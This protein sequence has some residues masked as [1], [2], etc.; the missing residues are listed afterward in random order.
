MLIKGLFYF[1]WNSLGTTTNH[2]IVCCG[3][4]VCVPANVCFAG[5]CCTSKEQDLSNR[6]ESNHRAKPGTDETRFRHIVQT[7]HAQAEHILQLWR[8]ST[9]KCDAHWL[10]W[11]YTLTKQLF[12]TTKQLKSNLGINK[13]SLIWTKAL[14]T[15]NTNAFALRSLNKKQQFMKAFP[16]VLFSGILN[17]CHFA[18]SVCVFHQV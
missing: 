4:C 18:G 1:I 10:K 8:W 14:S 3:V 12:S 2:V 15:W 11:F 13:R 17:I 7:T 6:A 5:F 9:Y 16:L